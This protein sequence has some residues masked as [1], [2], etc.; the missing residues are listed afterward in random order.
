MS[1]AYRLTTDFIK[2]EVRIVV[3]NFT[4]Q[5]NRF[6]QGKTVDEI[7]LAK[8]LSA[9]LNIGHFDFCTTEFVDFSKLAYRNEEE[10]NIYHLYYVLSK[11]FI[12]V[13]GEGNN[14]PKYVIQLRQ[15]YNKDLWKSLKEL[16][17]K[18]KEINEILINY[19][20]NNPEVI[21]ESLWDIL[22]NLRIYTA[23]KYG[24]NFA[25]PLEIKEGD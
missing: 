17:D 6:K 20:E 8:I 3:R 24:T 21:K 14:N 1:K 7:T 15:N 11:T 4:V 12:K 18:S 9:P 2:G 10:K 19:D 13:K 16:K 5:S 23:K 25:Y 22:K